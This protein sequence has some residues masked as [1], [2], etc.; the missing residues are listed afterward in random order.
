MFDAPRF[1][2]NIG[3]A[4][5]YATTG[6][7]WNNQ[8]QKEG[9]HSIQHYFAEWVSCDVA[10]IF[11]NLRK[12]CDNKR[13]KKLRAKVHFLGAMVLNMGISAKT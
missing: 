1:A 4:Q 13:Q 8:I 5:I 3:D 10:Q 9:N 11:G 2:A 6:R 12:T 7:D